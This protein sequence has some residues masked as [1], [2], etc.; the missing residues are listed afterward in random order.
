M[1]TW[2]YPK[3]RVTHHVDLVGTPAL[4]FNRPVEKAKVLVKILDVTLV[5]RNVDVKRDD[6]YIK[7]PV[8]GTDANCFGELVGDLD[9]DCISVRLET[10]N[11]SGCLHRLWR[12][13]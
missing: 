1:K 5:V 8:R 3:R 13:T 12:V 11:S 7:L 9:L 2:L 4:E 10:S 6:E